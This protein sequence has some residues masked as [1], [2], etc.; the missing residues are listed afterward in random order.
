M[1]KDL[2]VIITNGVIRGRDRYHAAI[3]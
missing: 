3:N 1:N 2:I